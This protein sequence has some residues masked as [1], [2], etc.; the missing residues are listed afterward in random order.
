MTEGAMRQASGGTGNSLF[1]SLDA[2]YTGILV[3]KIL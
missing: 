1:L 2:S 3:W